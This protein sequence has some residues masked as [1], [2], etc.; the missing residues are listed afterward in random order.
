MSGYSP[1]LKG[2][3]AFALGGF[4]VVCFP[5]IRPAILVE[6]GVGTFLAEPVTPLVY[7][8]GGVLIVLG[9]LAG[10][11]AF[12]RGSRADRVLA[13]ISVLL[14]AGL[15]AQY[16]QLFV[17]KV[18]RSSLNQSPGATAAMLPAFVASGRFVALGIRRHHVRWRGSAPS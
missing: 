17:L 8:T 15:A 5:F 3:I 9:L 4:G 7:F 13:C 18:H 12:R 16:F 1:S 14:I 6:S 2:W 11:D 10:V